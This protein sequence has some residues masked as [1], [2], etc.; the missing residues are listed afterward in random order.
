MFKRGAMILKKLTLLLVVLILTV[1]SITLIINKNKTEKF[2]NENWAYEY[3]KINKLHNQKKLTGKGVKLALIDSG[4]SFKQEINV[5]KGVNVLDPK[6]SYQ[7]NHGHGTHLAG[8]LTNK[9]IGVAPNIDLYVIKA[10]DNNLNGDINNVIEAVNYSIEEKV[11]IILMSFGTLKYSKKLESVINR[12]LRNNIVVISSVGNY[13]LQ[14][15]SDILYPAKFEGVI[16]VGALNMNGDIWKGTTVGNG[17]NV[18]LPGQYIKS[19]SK[20]GSFLY[21]SGTSMAAA[22]M[23]GLAALFFEEYSSYNKSTI[24]K[25]IWKKIK[26][27]DKI[28]GYSVMN[29]DKFF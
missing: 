23:A 19:Y 16:A 2:K 24:S 4:V 17:L 15:K 29:T 25:K 27:L 10:L 5:K 1:T 21:S 12:A 14:E 7:D 18:L 20:D 3:L 11:D 22:Y 26:N 28:N 6:R 13:G 9:D 8:I